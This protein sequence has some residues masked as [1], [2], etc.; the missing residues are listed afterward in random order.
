M[1]SAAIRANGAYVLFDFTANAFLHHMVR[2]IVGC[3]VYVGKGKCPPAWISELIEAR[4][5]RHAAPTF[6]ADG[7]Y[8]FKVRYEERWKLPAFP[9]MMPFHPDHGR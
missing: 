3:L 1:E 2:N 8:L 5:R 9:D 4:D 6:A 7:L